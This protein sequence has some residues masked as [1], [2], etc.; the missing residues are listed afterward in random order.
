M[1]PCMNALQVLNVDPAGR[2]LM[3]TYDA[4]LRSALA[5]D[6]Q[7]RP[8]AQPDEIFERQTSANSSSPGSHG[9]S[10]RA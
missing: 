2:L 8:Q 10:S 1:I 5:R 3:L 6:Y 7:G 9:R 4:L